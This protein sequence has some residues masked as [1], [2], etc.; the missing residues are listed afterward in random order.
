VKWRRGEGE[1]WTYS[2]PL[3]RILH[4]P[5]PI[6]VII[7]SQESYPVPFFREFRQLASMVTSTY[8]TCV[9]I[10]NGLVGMNNVGI[11]PLSLP[12]GEQGFP[13]HL[14][15]INLGHHLIM[16]I[17]VQTIA[18]LI[19]PPTPFSKGEFFCIII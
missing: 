3:L 10:Y 8:Q 15:R 12:R 1:M 7:K 6:M 13:C 16:R 17:L 4:F 18:T 14:S 2:F 19:N 9:S 5:M 11:P